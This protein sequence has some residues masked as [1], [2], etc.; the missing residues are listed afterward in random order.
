MVTIVAAVSMPHEFV[1]TYLMV[2]IPAVTPVTIPPTTVADPL[3]L[4]HVPPVITS[5]KVSV[6]PTHTCEMPF[7]ITVLI[8]VSE[9]HALATTYIM[10]SVPGVIPVTT[11]PETVAKPLVACQIPPVAVS[12]NV[13][14]EPMN[15]LLSPIIH[16]AKGTEVTV[17][18]FIAV[19]EPQVL[20]TT[21]LIVSMPGAIPVTIPAVTEV[22]PL[23]LLHTPPTVRSFSVITDPAQTVVTPVIAPTTGDAGLTVNVVVAAFVPQLLVTV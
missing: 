5:D 15:S 19:T 20:A 18:I 11:P 14:V 23:L 7:T 6:E 1:T 3:L 22:L 2:S 4:L 12:V 21:Y 17:T 9:P 13:T 16:P 10:V 8:A